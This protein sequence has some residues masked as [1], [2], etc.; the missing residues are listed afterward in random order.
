MKNF[1][2]AIA[3]VAFLFV[4]ERT[5]G[6]NQY[7]FD[8]ESLV[9][10]SPQIVE[11]QLG[12]EHRTNNVTVRQFK[13][14]TVHKGNL[15]A[16]QTIDVTA[17]EF[18]SVSSNSFWGN[19]KLKE[20]DK[21]FFFGDRARN[22]FL[23]D[24]P[25]NAEIYWPAPSG[26]RLVAGEKALN[27]FQ[28]NNPGPY[29]AILSGAATNTAIPTVTEFREQIRQSVARMENWKPLL[30]REA[31]LQDVPALLEIL[32]ERKQT[33]SRPHGF[34]GRDQI[35][36]RVCSRLVA[37]H[38]ISAL[39]N[40]LAIDDGFSWGLADG[41][42]SVAGRQFLWSKITDE[43]QPI[44][45][46]VKWANFFQKAGEGNPEEHQLKRIAEFAVRPNQDQKLQ[47]VLLDSLQQLQNWWRFTHGGNTPDADTQIGINE[48]AS[49]L[50]SFSEKTDSE[51]IK[52]KIDLVLAEFNGEKDGIISILRFGNYDASAR[53]LNYHYDILVWKGANLTTEIAF[54]NV[55]TGQKW[56]ASPNLDIKLTDHEQAGGIKDVTLPKDLPS[57]H[58]RVFYEFLQDGKVVCTSHNFETDL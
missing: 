47:A 57:G 13:I 42:D 46:R 6:M 41:F 58:Y 24:I 48:A 28:Y 10:M 54:Q 23:Y 27:F 1:W 5:Q 45:D 51:E 55:K 7:T 3:V 32:R 22:T 12:G 43:K 29:V 39:T 16:G 2:S 14:S 4:G 37:L 8:L 9:D 50:K 31:T 15:K 19:D 34:F 33:D 25:T 53:R 44:E 30:E 18:Y 26:I 36:E 52:Y 40:A 35:T 17:L 38:D 56:N 11:G 21:L 20:G 49:I